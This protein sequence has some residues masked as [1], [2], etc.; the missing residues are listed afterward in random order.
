[1]NSERRD[2]MTE[3]EKKDIYKI[4]AYLR[5]YETNCGLLEAQYNVALGHMNHLVNAIRKYPDAAMCV[6]GVP[7]MKALC[8][9]LHI[10]IEGIINHESKIVLP[11]NQRVLAFY[12]ENGADTDSIVE[13]DYEDFRKDAQG[14]VDRIQAGKL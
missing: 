9:R 8:E 6:T 1:M 13:M 3:Q 10:D 14:F 11:V 12:K 5:V 2:A 4:V 7:A